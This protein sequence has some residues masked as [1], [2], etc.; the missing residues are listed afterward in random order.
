MAYEVEEF[1][2]DYSNI[3]PRQL[4]KFMRTRGFAQSVTPDQYSGMKKRIATARWQL[5][6]RIVYGAIA[7][8]YTDLDS[9]PIATGLSLTQVR[10]ALASLTKRG[11]I[12]SFGVEGAS[13]TTS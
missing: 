11:N 1:G 2:T 12:T 8:G 3:D 6:E 5:E 10:E 7:E 9:L 4:K 13:K